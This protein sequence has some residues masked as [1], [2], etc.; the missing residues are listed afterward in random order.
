MQG[1]SEE[2]ATVDKER[3]RTG[4]LCG[5]VTERRRGGVRRWEEEGENRG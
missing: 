4:D 5:N 2:Q 1:L 3:R